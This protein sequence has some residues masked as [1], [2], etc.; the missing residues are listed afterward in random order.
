MSRNVRE[1][2]RDVE[3]RNDELND[4]NY[5]KSRLRKNQFLMN[6]KINGHNI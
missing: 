3:E 1:P 5:S 2:I 6:G 4:L